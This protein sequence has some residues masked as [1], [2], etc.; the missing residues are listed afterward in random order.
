MNGQSGTGFSPLEKVKKNSC[1]VISALFSVKMQSEK[2]PEELNEGEYVNAMY[3]APPLPVVWHLWTI[4]SE[5]QKWVKRVRYIAPP[6]YWLV[7]AEQESKVQSR[8]TQLSLS[9]LSS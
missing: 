7:M 4:Q 8:T 3:A 2:K 1:A 6:P 9:S 5:K